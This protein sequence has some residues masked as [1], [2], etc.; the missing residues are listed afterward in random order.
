MTLSAPQFNQNLGSTAKSMRQLLHTLQVASSG[1]GVATPT[2]LL[3]AA[4][5][6]LT[7]TIA[8]GKAFIPS[9][10][11]APTGYYHAINNAPLVVTHVTADVTNPRIDS[12]FIKE[13]DSADGG[14]APGSDG[15]QSILVNG[16]ATPGA[17][18]TNL[19]GIGSAPLNALLLAYVLVPAG[20]GTAASFTY[21]DR[22]PLILP[23]TTRTRFA[24]ANTAAA[25]GERIITAVNGLTVTLPA[26]AVDAQVTVFASQNIT[27]TVVTASSGLILCQ[28]N[29]GVTS[30]NLGSPGAFMT[31]QGDGTN[32]EIVSGIQDSGWI[33]LT[34]PGNIHNST[35]I[36]ASVRQLGDRIQMKGGI[37][38]NT[39][40]TLGGLT[41][42][43]TIPNTPAGMRP[44][45]NL[46]FCMPYTDTVGPTTAAVIGA[47]TTVGTII[48][49]FAWPNNAT[50]E[51]DGITFSTS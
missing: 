15:V 21:S 13:F 46:N 17:T 49:S 36:T 20:A 29:M 19:F 39:G 44:G 6:G 48:L 24:V 9:S 38:N 16:I 37:V 47:I 43:A 7:S 12:I 1:Y 10:V 5:T 51:F 8:S 2:D 50:L 35:A 45:V 27:G 40:G 22:R 14:D 33:P 31:F 4:G 3:A 18:L 30:I 25:L 28:G 26:P 34:L 42:L 11:D 41:V 32:W 23:R